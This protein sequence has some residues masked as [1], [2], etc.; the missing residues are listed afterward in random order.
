MNTVLLE[1]HI[2]LYKGE[3]ILETYDRKL[4]KV[5]DLLDRFERKEVRLIVTELSDLQEVQTILRSEH[6]SVDEERE[7]ES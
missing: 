7:E 2:R 3:W 6:A 1:G 4:Y 5:A